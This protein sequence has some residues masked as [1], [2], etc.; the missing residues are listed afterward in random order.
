MDRLPDLNNCYRETDEVREASS[1]AAGRIIQ[2]LTTCITCL[3]LGF[4]RS[5]SLTLVILSAVPLLL[6]LQ[7]ISQRFAGPL[8]A[9]ERKASARS[10]TLVERATAAISTVKAFNGQAHEKASLSKILDEN[11]S[12]KN[13]QGDPHILLM[14]HSQVTVA[15]HDPL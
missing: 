15:V 7:A 11:P 1:L 12:P 2:Y 14:R 10:A 5:W 13:G 4:A 6:L 8:L 9:E 3:V